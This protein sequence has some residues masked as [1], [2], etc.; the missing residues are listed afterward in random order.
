MKKQV[1]IVEEINLD[2]ERKVQK[3]LNDEYMVVKLDTS[4]SV[5]NDIIREVLVAVVEKNV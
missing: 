2:F 3:Y 1:I 4:V 5:S